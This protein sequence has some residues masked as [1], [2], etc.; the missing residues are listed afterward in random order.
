MIFPAEVAAAQRMEG[1]ED[2]PRDDDPMLDL[3]GVKVGKREGAA[4]PFF[5]ERGIFVSCVRILLCGASD[6]RMLVELA[7]KGGEDPDG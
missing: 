4:A 3:G 5:E 2:E 7:A 6:R 1:D